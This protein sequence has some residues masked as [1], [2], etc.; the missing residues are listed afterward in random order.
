[1]RCIARWMRRRTT[2]RA[3][4]WAALVGLGLSAACGSGEEAP[5]RDGG[6]EA[7]EAPV[8]R[9]EIPSEL[10]VRLDSA[11]AAFEA[12]EFEAALR[13]YRA[14]AEGAPEVAAGWFG[15]YMV[16]DARGEEAAAAEA[17]ARAREMAPRAG[18]DGPP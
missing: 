2:S 12:D 1:M 9:T 13:H 11:N 16:H 5:V 4:R 3:G 15:I 6:R 14:V 8:G 10:L 18:S 7:A 17:L